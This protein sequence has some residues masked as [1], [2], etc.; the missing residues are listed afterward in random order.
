MRYH[1]FLLSTGSE[2]LRDCL[3]LSQLGTDSI[4]WEREGNENQ[5]L[6]ILGISHT[7]STI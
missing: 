5:Y 4:S 1:L 7:E 6:P 3:E 2:I